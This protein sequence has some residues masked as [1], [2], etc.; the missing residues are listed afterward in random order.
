MFESMY[1]EARKM[2]M[3][4]RR[5]KKVEMRMALAAIHA[6][7]KDAEDEEEDEEHEMEE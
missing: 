6:A 1:K 5:E 3:I 2:T 7:S 4:E